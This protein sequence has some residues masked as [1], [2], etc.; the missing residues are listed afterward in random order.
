MK[1]ASYGK[2]PK[3]RILLADLVA[4]T[5]ACLTALFVRY[6]TWA[7]RFDR[8]YITLI[9]SMWLIQVVIFLTVDLKNRSIYESDPFEN[10]VAVIRDRTI[11]IIMTVLY[12][13]VTQQ[14]EVSS[15]FVIGA[16]YI[17]SIVYD[18]LVRMLLRYL[19]YR[20]HGKDMQT[21][22][23]E[24]KYP[25][26]AGEELS[27]ILSEN[28]DKDVLIHRQGASD[29]EYDSMIETVD[30]TGRRVYAGLNVSGYEVKKGIASDV[31][32]YLTI[33]V[34]IRKEKYTLLGVEYA[35][36][37]TEEATLHVIRHLRELRGKYICF[38]NVHTLVMAHE[39]EEYRKILNGSAYTFADGNPIAKRE[40][41]GGHTGVERVAGPDFMTHM[42]EDTSDG[43]VSHYFYGSSPETIE[44]LGRELKCKYPDMDIRGMYSPP[45]RELTHDEDEQDIKRINDSGADIV[46]IG[47]GAPKQEKWM[48]DH[49][50]KINGVMMG[51]GAGFDFHAQTIKRA[52]VW[53]QRI[54]MEWLYRLCQDP[55]RLF[56]RYVVT[57]AKYYVYTLTDRTGKQNSVDMVQRDM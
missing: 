30:K 7:C 33:P 42:F 10:L 47:L 24:L 34:G 23:V 43:S 57:N 13:Y 48:A 50:G 49:A 11:I 8:L 32:G 37:R 31:A 5:A 26:P 52:P 27:A 29:E 54:G 45:Y 28:S 20:Q 18:Y 9:V 44:A 12:L 22:L 36:A 53:I 55:G 56:K 16:I 15:R 4:M 25:Y 3:R 14:G 40:V 6:E 39:N 38:S 21:Q 41:R 2:F 35:I 51:V 46:W 1:Q 17:F 19:Y